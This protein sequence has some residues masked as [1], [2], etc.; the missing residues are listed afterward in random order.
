M[1]ADNPD[2]ILLLI[3]INGLGTGSQG[4]L[5]MLVNTI[6]TTDPSVQLIV[7]QITPLVRRLQ[8]VRE[9]H[10]IENRSILQAAMFCSKSAGLI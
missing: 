6:V 10:L 4:A 7:A 2:I 5:D 1:T 9:Y 3:G 8:D